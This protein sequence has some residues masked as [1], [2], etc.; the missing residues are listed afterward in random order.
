MSW[1]VTDG[2]ATVR[3]GRENGNAINDLLLS[4]L[5]T[6]FQACEADPEVRGVLLAAEGKIFCPGLDLKE[7][8][9]LDRAGMGRFME[10][11]GATLLTLYTHPKPVVAALHGHALAGG[12]ILG[13]AADWRV[14]RRGALVGLNEIRVGVPLPFGVAMM[15][16]D[17]VPSA[18][19]EEIALLGRNYR[20]DEAVAA[21]LANE[22]AD[23]D[24][25]EA[26]CRTRLEEFA[27]KDAAAFAITKRYLRCVTVE[28]IRADAPSLLGDFLDGWFSA[29]TR[30]R[31]AAIVAELG[32]KD[33]GKA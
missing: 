2:L 19:R 7:L 3:F 15:L 25:F 13:L 32:A 22:L 18:R 14:L 29:P 17:Q 9:P 20:D 28:R 16:R 5:M 26:V 30:E 8:H 1:S 27:S 10:R 31:I 6:A 23:A 24:G 33:K 21:G 12:L 4:G 11:F